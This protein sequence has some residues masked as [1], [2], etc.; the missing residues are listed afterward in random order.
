MAAVNAFPHRP[1]ALD[2]PLG[3][4]VAQ[5]GLELDPEH[6]EGIESMTQE[7]AFA[8]RVHIGPLVGGVN[9]GPA[10]F[11]P[12][13]RPPNVHV[14]GGPHHPILFA[15]RHEDG[16]RQDRADRS[17]LHRLGH[18]TLEIL[19]RTHP[20]VGQMNPDGRIRSGPGQTGNVFRAQ[21]FQANMTVFKDDRI[22]WGFRT[23]VTRN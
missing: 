11:Q 21:G 8:A 16:E 17:G 23:H 9:E 2:G 18:Q 13:M 1:D 20:G 6:A 19:Y 10:D 22:Q 5:V 14:A 3:T 12:T 4:E 7:K 15:A